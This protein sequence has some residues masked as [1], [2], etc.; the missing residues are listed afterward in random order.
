MG[1][2]PRSEIGGDKMGKHEVGHRAVFLDRD[3]VLNRIV[4]RNG[5]PY[6]PSSIQDFELYDDVAV[7]CARLKAAGFLLIVVTNQPDVGRGT[8]DRE[9]VEA[10]HAK[11][12]SALPSLDRIEVCYHAGE[13]YAERCDCRKPRP[14]LILQ[15]AAELNIDLK[16]SYVIG[17]RWRDIDCARA[18]GC[19]AIFIQRDYKETLREAPDFTVTNFGDA[20]DAVLRNTAL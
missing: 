10:M 8:Q 4:I 9:I 16:E 12:Q 1:L 17:D 14:G 5:Q 3:G 6:P 15:A 20:V 18:A 11:L 2:S 13:Q 19:Q 7:G